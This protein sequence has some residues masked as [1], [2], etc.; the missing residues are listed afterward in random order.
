MPGETAGGCHRFA[1]GARLARG[2]ELTMNKRHATQPATNP[3]FPPLA[4]YA[5]VKPLRPERSPLWISNLTSQREWSGRKSDLFRP[6]DDHTK[7]IF[8]T[9]NL[10][11]DTWAPERNPLFRVWR[12][13]PMRREPTPPAP[14]VP[15]PPLKPSAQTDVLLHPRHRGDTY[16]NAHGDAHGDAQ[17]N[18]GKP[19]G[20]TPSQEPHT[21]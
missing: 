12:E 21:P 6:R 5:T 14:A 11:L 1:L 13:E 20:I 15:E 19:V 17:G 4:I 16:R 8:A 10:L 9:T 3:I 18:N 7:P 2:Y